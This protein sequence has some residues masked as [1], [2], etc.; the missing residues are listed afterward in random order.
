[1][2][3]CRMM[4]SVFGQP[5]CTA[6]EGAWF[7]RRESVGNANN[8]N[9]QFSYLRVAGDGLIPLDINSARVA[10]VRTG[11][12][13]PF[14]FEC[15]FATA[16]LERTTRVINADGQATS[17]MTDFTTRTFTPGSRFLNADVIQELTAIMAVESAVTAGMQVQ[18]RGMVHYQPGI[19]QAGTVAFQWARSAAFV[20]FM[21][22][23]VN[24]ISYDHG[25]DTSYR[26]E[27]VAVA[28][29]AI[30]PQFW[31]NDILPLGS[32]VTA[33]FDSAGTALALPD[34]APMDIGMFAGLGPAGFGAGE[35]EPNLNP[36]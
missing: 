13:M 29:G 10:G 14:F 36:N 25:T 17:I 27:Y 30:P 12:Q 22:V 19:A 32:L 16:R 2:M 23:P 31:M 5:F 7:D 4:L 33:N 35:D 21:D 34:L 28:G 11:V 3:F 26:F 18:R 9:A 24:L 20:G 15:S 1:M 6:V 8:D